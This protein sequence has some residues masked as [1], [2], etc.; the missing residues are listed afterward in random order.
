MDMKRLL[1]TLAAAVGIA[2]P[3][4]A[5]YR[6]IIPQQPI[7]PWI[8]TLAPEWSKKLGEKIIIDYQPGA[9]SVPGVVKFDKTDRQ[10][11]KVILQ[12][13]NGSAEALLTQKVDFDMDHWAPIGLNHVTNTVGVNKDLDVYK[14]KIRMPYSP[15]PATNADAIGVVLQICGPD[16]DFKGYLDCY[17]EKMKYITSMQTNEANLAYAK[18]ELNVNANGNAGYR[19]QLLPMDINRTWFTSNQ[20]DL[21]TGKD[22]DKSV[23][24]FPVY[25]DVYKAHWGKLPSDSNDLWNAYHLLRNYRDVLQKSLWV[26]KGNPN[27]QKLIDSLRATLDDKEVRAKIEEKI[28]PFP[29][30]YGDEVYNAT[31]Q[32]KAQ[33]TERALKTVVDWNHE[34]FGFDTVY[35]PELVKK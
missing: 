6:I 5:D 21:K 9:M 13:L 14:E 32:L 29:W 7:Q 17:R 8:E 2:G 33:T 15:S 28:G 22:L 3:A 34:A 20:M 19:Q 11:D 27:R 25:N 4:L 1:L 18:N 31:A 16:K 30:I 26:N 24:V 10:D 35:K 12:F 23:E